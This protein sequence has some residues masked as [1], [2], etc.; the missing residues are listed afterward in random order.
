MLILPSRP[1][2]HHS[3]MRMDLLRYESNERDINSEPEQEKCKVK[4]LSRGRED[5][6]H[7]ELSARGIFSRTG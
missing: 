6:F 4:D 5:V 1:I 2:I 3:P 7:A